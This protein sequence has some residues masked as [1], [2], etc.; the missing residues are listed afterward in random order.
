MITRRTIDRPVSL[1]GIGL[2]GGRPASVTVAPAAPGTGIVFCRTDSGDHS[3]PIPARYDRVVDAPL[4]TSLGDGTR[5][6]IGT[7]EH[8]MAAFAGLGISDAKVALDG[9]EVPVLDGS[10][11]PFARAIAGAGLRDLG[12]PVRA[13]R[14]L[15]PVTVRVADRL[16]RLSPAARFEMEFT[17]SFA[18]AAIGEQSCSLP[19]AGGALLAELSDARTFGCLSAVASLRRAGLG[20]GGGL[21]SV[22]VVDRG[23]VLNGEGLRRPDEFVRHK[24]L[25]A[26]GD[27]ALAGAPII[28]RYTGVKAGHALTNALLRALFAAPGAWCW[29][30]ADASEVPGGPPMLPRVPAPAA[31]VAV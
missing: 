1:R 16:A 13:I 11:L 25:D 15:R 30:E 7:V 31:P 10:A 3:H 19:L 21:E 17:I 8:L 12:V 27:L 28:G 2:H 24:M 26:A 20:L 14:I 22:V 6:M 29:C 23:R 5:P 4:S 18:D 9:P